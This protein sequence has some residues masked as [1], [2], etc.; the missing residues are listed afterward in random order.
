MALRYTQL[1][2][3]GIPADDLDSG[4]VRLEVPRMSHFQQW[5]ALRESSREVLQPFEP[6][7]AEDDLS[8]A[9]FR[10]RLRRYREDRRSGVG[11]PFFIVATQT[12]QLVGGCNLNNI[13]RGVKQSAAIGYWS[14]LA[15]RRCG[16]VRAAIRASLGYA[17]GPL[18][19]HR[20]EAACMPHNEASLALLRSLG[21]LDEGMARGYLRINGSWRDHLLL[22]VVHEE[23]QE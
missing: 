19:L 17:F 14:G 10:R 7:W 18:G 11:A 5:A 22:A 2:S 1:I 16:Y 9:G 3:D 12:G 15:Y 6:K 23:A 8:R 4:P 20:V 21:F 13:M